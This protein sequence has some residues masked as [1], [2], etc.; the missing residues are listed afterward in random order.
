MSSVITGDDISGATRGRPVTWAL[1]AFSV[2]LVCFVGP[3]L[4]R[5]AQ[6]EARVEAVDNRGSAALT[7]HIVE[8]RAADAVRDGRLVGLEKA[9]ELRGA[10]LDRIEGDVKQLLKLLRQ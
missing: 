10:Q 9:T 6:L 8:A 4:M 7:S 3:F 1:V 5:A 2:Q